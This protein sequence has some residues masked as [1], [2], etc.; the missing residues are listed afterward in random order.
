[1][2]IRNFDPR[3]SRGGLA[4]RDPRTVPDP[5]NSQCRDGSASTSKIADGLALITRATE[6]VRLF[7]MGCSQS[8]L[9]PEHGPKALFQ[10]GVIKYEARVGQCFGQHPLTGEQCLGNHFGAEQELWAK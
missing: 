8:G 4:S 3:L 10:C 7:D 9:A 2:S 1:M 5:S 6:R